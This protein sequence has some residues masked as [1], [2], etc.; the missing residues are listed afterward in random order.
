MDEIHMRSEG[1]KVGLSSLLSLE[2]PEI[3]I[4]PFAITRARVPA[5]V[6]SNPPLLKV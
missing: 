2:C 4:V 5:S 1:S 3:F 6:D